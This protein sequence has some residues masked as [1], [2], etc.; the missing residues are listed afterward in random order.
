[1]PGAPTSSYE[2]SGNEQ[3]VQ[4]Q[5]ETPGTPTRAYTWGMAPPP[6]PGPRPPAP[7]PALTVRGVKGVRAPHPEWEGA[8]PRAGGNLRPDLGNPQEHLTVAQRSEK[9]KFFSEADRGHPTAWSGV[10]SARGDDHQGAPLRGD[11]G[12]RRPGSQ[13]STPLVAT[14]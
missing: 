9:G 8:V 6:R 13:P 4:R 3:T 12:D 1:M 11:A 5:A 14:P 10:C 2:R 7:A